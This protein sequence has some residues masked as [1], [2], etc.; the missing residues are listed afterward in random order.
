MIMWDMAICEGGV[1]AYFRLVRSKLKPKKIRFDRQVV[2][3]LP[4][5]AQK[6][7]LCSP[8]PRNCAAKPQRRAAMDLE[9]MNYYG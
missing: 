7:V 6:K 1:R 4:I 2:E 5:F 3:K 8:A 9:K